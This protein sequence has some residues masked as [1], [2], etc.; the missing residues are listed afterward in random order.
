MKTFSMISKS[1]FFGLILLMSASMYA[2]D[3]VKVSPK[4]YKKVLLDNE[5][6]RVIQ[7]EFAEINSITFSLKMIQL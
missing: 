7:V 3:A 1:L 4:E 2:Q 5:K 6:V